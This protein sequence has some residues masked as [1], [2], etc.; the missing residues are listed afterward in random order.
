MTVLKAHNEDHEPEETRS[1]RATLESIYTLEY[2]DDH[3][4]PDIES[5]RRQVFAQG[6]CESLYCDSDELLMAEDTHCVGEDCEDEC[7]IPEEFKTLPGEATVDVMAFL[8]IR[9]AEPIR[10]NRQAQEWE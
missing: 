2:D 8:G 7:L 6:T 5:L 10:V 4:F 9:R 1:F 3:R